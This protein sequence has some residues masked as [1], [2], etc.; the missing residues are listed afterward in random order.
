MVQRIYVLC[1]EQNNP[2]NLIHSLRRLS[3]KTKE[4]VL[5]KT[6]FVFPTKTPPQFSFA[7]DASQLLR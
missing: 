4:K 6:L 7:N 1:K 5:N 2:Q 3:Q